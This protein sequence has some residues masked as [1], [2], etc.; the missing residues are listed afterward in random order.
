MKQLI[1]TF[2]RP[3]QRQGNEFLGALS[4][5]SPAED[6]DEPDP[7]TKSDPFKVSEDPPAPEE[8]PE[9]QNRYRD[10]EAVE[11]KINEHSIGDRAEPMLRAL[12]FF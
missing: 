8:Y 12:T 6:E 7:D 9:H 3:G 4:F 10:E 1:W 11:E 5:S 2:W